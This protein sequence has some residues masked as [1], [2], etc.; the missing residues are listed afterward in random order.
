MSG[1]VPLEYTGLLVL[2]LLL[3]LNSWLIIENVAKLSLF[4]RYYFGKC[5]SEL[6]QQVPFP[7]C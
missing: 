1:L 7:V 5:Y 2:H 4:C 3:V 6:A